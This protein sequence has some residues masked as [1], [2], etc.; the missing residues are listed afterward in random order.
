MATKHGFHYSYD[1]TVPQKRMV[2][3][4]IIMADP[5]D[6]ST[7]LA[8][9]LS[10]EGKFQFVN[11]PHRMYEWLEDSYPAESDTI[12]SDTTVTNSTTVTTITVTTVKLFQV[13]DIIEIGAEQ[14]YVSGVNTGTGVLTV[15][16]GFGSTTPATSASTATIN[17]R[18]SARQEGAD[19]SDSPFTEAVSGYNYSVIMHKDITISRTAQLVQNYGMSSA[20][21]FEIDKKM[22][23][24][25]ERLNRLPFY[26]KRAVGTSS[27]SRS[28]GGFG[29][30]LSTNTEAKSAAALLR[31][32]IDDALTNVFS[33]GGRTDLIICDT[34]GQRKINEFFE[35]YVSTDRT[36]RVGGVLVKQLQHPITG[37][38]VDVMVDRHCPAGSMFLLDSRWVGFLTIDPFFYEELAKV[39]DGLNGQI[40]GE[41]GFVM[42]YEKA[43]ASITGYSTSA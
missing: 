13:G 26:G 1:N 39:G 27:A 15:T 2:T 38:L 12:A 4:R 28:A 25:M 32:D 10:N 29:V 5:Y 8:L 7:I 17:I 11:T 34:H 41:Y 42:A 36:E 21:D 43:H 31:D 16:R 35:G 14:M 30:F 33:N 24:L 6:I 9:G 18:Y 23:I 3:D 22:D 40:V 20:L 37:A 19:S